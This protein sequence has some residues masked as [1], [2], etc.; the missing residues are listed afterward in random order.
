MLDSLGANLTVKLH[1]RVLGPH[2]GATVSQEVFQDFDEVVHEETPRFNL[3]LS[4]LL[5]HWFS[6]FPHWRQQC[7]SILQEVNT[8]FGNLK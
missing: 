3:F 2:Q 5:G 8:C 6:Y 7:V 4:S 1:E